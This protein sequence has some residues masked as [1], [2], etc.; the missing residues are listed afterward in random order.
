MTYNHTKGTKAKLCGIVIFTILLVAVPA[1]LFDF[2]YV[3][4]ATPGAH[5][6]TPL[7]F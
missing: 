5:W 7:F 1:V 3:K 6:E 4:I 2:Y